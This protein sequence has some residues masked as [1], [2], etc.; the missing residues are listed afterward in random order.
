MKKFVESY[1]SACKIRMVNV[2]DSSTDKE[3]KVEI[4]GMSGKT[5]AVIGLDNQ[6]HIVIDSKQ[7]TGELKKCLDELDKNGINVMYDDN[8]KVKAEYRSFADSIKKFFKS[9]YNAA[10]NLAKTEGAEF[11][12]DSVM[13]AAGPA[14]L[15]AYEVVKS[16][17]SIKGSKD[18]NKDKKKEDSSEEADYEMYFADAV[19]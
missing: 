5:L 3:S 17:G 15:L 1:L 18:K 12:I 19:S 7:A 10:K 13:K 4:K 8:G 9:T 11:A 6:G 14:G 16:L 2:H